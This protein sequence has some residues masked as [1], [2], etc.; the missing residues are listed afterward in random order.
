MDVVTAFVMRIAATF[1]NERCV[2]MDHGGFV[3]D[4]VDMIG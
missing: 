1:E 2:A 4:W 3:V